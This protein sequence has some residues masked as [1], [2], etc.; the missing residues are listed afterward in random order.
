MNTDSLPQVRGIYLRADALNR[1]TGL[2][3]G[4]L[5]HQQLADLLGMPNTTIWRLTTGRKVSDRAIVA[6][7]DA[8]ARLTH[9][10]QV[11]APGFDDLFEIRAGLGRGRIAA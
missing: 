2:N 1:V 6:F 3:A 10:R 5:S 7:L 9:Q 8:A 4:D 11:P